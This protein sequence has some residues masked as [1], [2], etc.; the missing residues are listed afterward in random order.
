MLIRQGKK[1]FL[2]KAVLLGG[3]SCAISGCS[4]IRKAKT[5]QLS[6]IIKKAR[7][8][9]GTPFRLGGTTQEGIDCSGL[10]MVSFREVG[11]RL[12]RTSEAQSKVGR[13]IAITKLRPGDLVFFA[14]NQ[15]KKRKVS[16]AGIV[17]QV[18]GR[19]SVRFI[20]AS[21]NRGVIE[22]ELFSPYYKKAYRKA[23]RVI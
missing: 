6:T 2:L 10:V 12:P 1:Y 8:F 14:L 9:Q 20:H 7:S 11:I 4:L 13:W 17:T 5:A 23:R 22:S 18:N 16:H 19:K 21:R 3:I 15:K